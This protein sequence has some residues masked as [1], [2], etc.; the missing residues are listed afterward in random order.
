MIFKSKKDAFIL[1]TI[2]LL[3]ILIIASPWIIWTLDYAMAHEQYR[4]DM[5][6]FWS[7]KKEL[8]SVAEFMLECFSQE[9]ATNAE[10]RY[11]TYN[12]LNDC[13]LTVVFVYDIHTNLRPH[14]ITLDTELASCFR[15]VLDEMNGSNWEKNITVWETRV[16]FGLI[17]SHYSYLRTGEPN[18]NH[19]NHIAFTK[20]WYFVAGCEDM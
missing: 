19:V 2:L 12:S 18:A 14:T 1:I 20:N 17:G 10:L 13:E 9:K 7:H 4:Y 8:D 15:T 6:D 16:C 5:I 3:C 11:A